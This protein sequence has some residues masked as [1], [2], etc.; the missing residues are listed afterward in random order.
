MMIKREIHITMSCKFPES[1]FSLLSCR[2]AEE[3]ACEGPIENGRGGREIEKSD[4][5][6]L[7][8]AEISL[9][10]KRRLKRLMRD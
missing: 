2:V 10:P 6:I 7:V 1:P 4:P 9:E 8:K 5:A 3:S